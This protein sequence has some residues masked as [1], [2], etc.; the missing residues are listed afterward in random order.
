MTATHLFLSNFTTTMPAPDMQIVFAPSGPGVT[1]VQ[2]LAVGQVDT[3]K[4]LTIESETV[5]SITEIVSHAG[6]D[7]EFARAGRRRV[8]L[9]MSRADLLQE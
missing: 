1:G 7:E 3:G 4:P 5:N 6:T 2:Y 8:A 9:A